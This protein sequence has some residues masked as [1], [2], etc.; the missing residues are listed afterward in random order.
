MQKSIKAVF[1]EYG[2]VYKLN[3]RE[4]PEDRDV[5]RCPIAFQDR[6]QKKRGEIPSLSTSKSSEI[7][8]E[9]TIHITICFL[10]FLSVSFSIQ[11]RRPLTQSNV[12][13]PSGISYF[14]FTF[15]LT[16]A[17]ENE[18][19]VDT[20]TVQVH[21]FFGTN[22][23]FSFECLLLDLWYGNGME[24][25]GFVMLLMSSPRAMQ[26]PVLFS[27]PDSG[28]SFPFILI[29][30]KKACSRGFCS[31]VPRKTPKILIAFDFLCN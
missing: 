21:V 26:K 15:I 18:R 27:E 30:N 6:L 17:L 10:L 2:S 19:L 28:F 11:L 13:S 16:Q 5:S 20:I 24:K 25:S 29:A 1:G 7:L 3:K 14:P 4:T 12:S 23:R 9:T 31:T 22:I 8:K